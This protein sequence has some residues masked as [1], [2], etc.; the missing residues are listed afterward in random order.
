MDIPCVLALCYTTCMMK[1]KSFIHSDIFISTNLLHIFNLQG[2]DGWEAG[3]SPGW[4]VMPPQS[5]IQTLIH[6]E[7][8]FN[9]ANLSGRKLENP[10]NWG[11]TIRWQ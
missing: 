7:A 3:I 6:T 5:T 4:S 10:A 9:V 11:V 1:K 8:Q 2:D